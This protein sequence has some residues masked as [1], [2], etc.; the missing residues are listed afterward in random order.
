MS[1][2]TLTLTQVETLFQNNEQ[3]PELNI[4]GDDRYRRTAAISATPPVD[5]T[6]AHKLNEESSGAVAEA[7]TKLT[8]LFDAP[9]ETIT[10]PRPVP[11]P[12]LDIEAVMCH[13][14]HISPHFVDGL[15]LQP[16]LGDFDKKVAEHGFEAAYNIV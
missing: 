9:V 16:E 15:A 12:G 14:F 1:Q 2:Q 4:T 8:D 3:R 6:Y 7:V 5:P 13:V 11:L 10:Y